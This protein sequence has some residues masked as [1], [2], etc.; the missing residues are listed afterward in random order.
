MD[1]DQTVFYLTPRNE[2]ALDIV[3]HPDNS[4]RTCQDPTDPKKL[5]LRIGLDQESKSPPCLVSFGRSDHSDVVLCNCSPETDQCYFDF[6]KESGELLLHDTSKNRDTQLREVEV[7]N[8][9]EEEEEDWAGD[10]KAREKLGFAQLSEAHR[11]CVVLLGP[12]LSHDRIEWVFQMGIA[13]FRLKPGST[14][15]IE[16]RLAFARN[17]SNGGTL[18]RTLRHRGTHDLQ[19]KVVR[20]RKLK[21]LG[22]GNQGQ[23]HEIVDMCTGTHY[24]CKIVDMGEAATQWK[25]HTGKD[26]RTRVKWEV[27][28]VR[29]MAHPHIV[30]YTHIRELRSSPNIQIFMPIYEGNLEDLL[31][32]HRAD[33][34]ERVRNMT[35]KMLYQ[36]LQAL[37]FVHSHD[38]P[39]IHR[40][41][42]P[43]NI[44]YRG[45]DFFLT[46]FGIA[47]AVNT[48]STFIGTD[49]YI[50]PEVREKREQTPKVDIWGLG[51]TV[52]ACLVEKSDDSNNEKPKN[53]EKWYEYL[54]TSLNRHGFPFA[55][56][57]NVDTDARPTAHDLLT[58]ATLSSAAPPLSPRPRVTTTV[59]STLPVLMDWEQTAATQPAQDDKSMQLSQPSPPVHPG[60]RRGESDKS[61]TPGSQRGKGRK[62]KMSSQDGDAPSERT[63]GRTLRPRPKR[64]RKA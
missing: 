7:V 39:I 11:R 12:D 10:G 26:Y 52:A 34:K 32:H 53:W 40:D 29:N 47:K 21:R 27:E 17:T 46:D 4:N 62:R 58:N 5:S 31:E 64:L 61:A 1:T 35:S 3:K 57:V 44:L 18:Q 51:V 19:L 50:A 30:P 38:P 36:M 63:S 6:N 43:R 45:D 42:K 20:L 54:Q 60:A 13:E 23:V 25:N 33:G 2:F 41:V 9:D 15:P 16:K 14:Q 48:S 28:T 59:N 8:N 55:S 37:N 22:K 49:L 56:M 24:A